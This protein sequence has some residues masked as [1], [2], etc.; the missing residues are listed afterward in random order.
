MFSDSAKLGGTAHLN[1]DIIEGKILYRVIHLHA[2]VLNNLHEDADFPHILQCRI[3]GVSVFV[4]CLEVQDSL[5][6]L[7]ECMDHK[8]RNANQH[9]KPV[10]APQLVLIAGFVAHLLDGQCHPLQQHQHCQWIPVHSPAGQPSPC[11]AVSSRLRSLAI[12]SYTQIRLLDNEENDILMEEQPNQCTGVVISVTYCSLC[13]LDQFADCSHGS[14]LSEP[15]Q[16]SSWH[17][18][19]LVEG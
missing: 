13:F 18:G 15:L 16:P 12:C 5:D 14:R 2:L 17:G 9:E 10:L 19:M 8:A 4:I 6:V 1:C 3:T 7:V 11:C